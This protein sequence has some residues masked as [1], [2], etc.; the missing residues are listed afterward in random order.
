MSLINKND[1][2]YVAG[3][4]GMV[5]KAITKFL[6]NNSY[7]NLLLPN[8]K[9]LDLLNTT[10]VENWF[11][12]NK[13]EVVI[14]AAA[15]VGGIAANYNYPADFI[16]ENIKIQTNII[17]NSWKRGVKKFLFLGSS[18]IYPKLAPQP[19]KEEYLLTGQLEPTNEPYAIAKIAGIK[20]CSALKKQ[21]GF[22]AISLMPTNLYGP[23]D[24]YN[25]KS[26]HVMPALIR[27]FYEA[28][29]KNKSEVICWGSGAP[30][31]EFLYVDDL[32]EAAIFI[33]ENICSES[34][35]NNKFSLNLDSLI[36][37]GTGLDI[38]IKNLAEMIA[39][40][41]NYK[42]NIRWETNKPD[43]TPRKLLDVS[44]LKKL[45]WQAKTSLEKGINLT[46][47]NFEKEFKNKSIRL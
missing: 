43:G 6:K 42:G 9:D 36:N 26:S 11:Y 18:C 21:Y 2:I 12:E 35:P 24:N 40:E 44:Q 32:A 41:L 34:D 37:V 20:L 13:P 19:I 38:S 8:R 45:G 23:G 25:L 22:D 7:K 10:A 3:H 1:L 39:K 15:K 33:L 47:K 30:K 16:L 29:L 5:G 27:K 4:N 46:I 17:E 28:K 31:R 14:L